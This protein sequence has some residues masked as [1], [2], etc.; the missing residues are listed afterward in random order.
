MAIVTPPPCVA[1]LSAALFSLY[2]TA[3]VQGLQENHDG[4]V[5]DRS[6]TI[7]NAL[8]LP[9]FV[10]SHLFEKLVSLQCKG[11]IQKLIH[12]YLSKK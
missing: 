12:D 6:N 5:Q 7:A 4:L 8:E 1:K 11:T 2:K 10:V 9:R 3:S